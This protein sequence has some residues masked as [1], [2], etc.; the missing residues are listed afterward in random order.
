MTINNLEQKL[1]A[2]SFAQ[3]SISTLNT[4]K[5]LTPEQREHQA[6]LS[7][8]FVDLSDIRDELRWEQLMPEV[9]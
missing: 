4:I 2:L 5:P 6:M 3:N 9:K 1:K 8:L 7:E